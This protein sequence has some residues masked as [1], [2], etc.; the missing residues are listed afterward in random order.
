[1][2]YV[3]VDPEVVFEHRGVIVFH[4][5]SS[6]YVGHP[7]RYWYTTNPKNSDECHLHGTHGHFDVRMFAGRWGSTPNVAEWEEFWKPRFRTEDECI[8]ALIEGAIDSGKVR[9]TEAGN[10]V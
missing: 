5:Y 7:C 3:M 2:P 10:Q 8:L 4:T 9:Q 6:G 1:M